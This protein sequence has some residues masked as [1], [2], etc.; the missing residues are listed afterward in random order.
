M[1]KNQK[2]D[3][4][5]N[6]EWMTVKNLEHPYSHKGDFP[7]DVSKLQRRVARNP[8]AALFEC[9]EQLQQLHVSFRDELYNGLQYGYAIARHLSMDPKAFKEFYSLP[10]FKTGKRQFKA[11]KQQEKVLRHVMNYVF[12]ATSVTARKRTGKYAAGLN[13][14]MRMGMPAHI[15]AT[16]I[17][18][19]GGIEKLYEISVETE[20]AKPKRIRSPS[21]GPEPDFLVNGKPVHLGGKAS[22]TPAKDWSLDGLEGDPNEQREER[23]DS[24][25][26]VDPDD[27]LQMGGAST[28]AG[29]A[30]MLNQGRDPKGRPTVSLE[31]SPKMKARLLGLKQGE[32]M[33]LRIEGKGLDEAN[34]PEEWVRLRV[35]HA[36]QWP[37]A[38]SKQIMH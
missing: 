29:E 1:S 20:A 16:Q 11:S 4:D 23:G 26:E 3:H 12:N 6:D 30:L 9:A 5:E 35:K 10:F 33:V 36:F 2:S 19:D 21:K 27:D 13:G 8:M 38:R 31:V 37:S 22:K 25:I 15:V 7:P 14:Y 28:A 34:D 32:R 18:A 24:D 17:K